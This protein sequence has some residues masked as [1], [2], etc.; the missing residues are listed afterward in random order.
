MQ[1]VLGVSESGVQSAP[2][3]DHP[4]GQSIAP[5]LGPCRYR[6]PATERAPTRAPVVDRRGGER[7]HGHVRLRCAVRRTGRKRPVQQRLYHLRAVRAQCQCDTT[8]NSHTRTGSRPVIQAA[9]ALHRQRGAHAILDSRYQPAACSTLARPTSA[10]KACARVVCLAA[11]PRKHAPSDLLVASA[12]RT[13]GCRMTSTG[14]GSSAEYSACSRPA[15][16]AAAAASVAARPGP[17]N[18]ASA[19]PRPP[20]AAAP[21]PRPGRP[22]PP[23]SAA[24]AAAASRSA[25][26]PAACSRPARPSRGENLLATR[27]VCRFAAC[28][29]SRR[30]PLHAHAA[31]SAAPSFCQQGASSRRRVK[32]RPPR[33]ARQQQRSRAA[34]TGRPPARPRGSCARAHAHSRGGR[35][36]GAHQRAI[37]HTTGPACTAACASSSCARR[38]KRALRGR[39]PS[40]VS[41]CC[42]CAYVCCPPQHDSCAPRARSGASRAQCSPPRAELQATETRSA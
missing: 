41:I 32:Q 3:V 20:S 27:R 16:S 1:Y 42:A 10:C 14:G 17:L 33:A 40:A 12:A 21:P 7:E 11:A 26:A 28:A 6:A 22:P 9:S 29:G 35:A 37:C 18:P 24:A 25:T 23:P 4:A 5:G 39:R 19:P 38:L 2:G 8:N 36:R 30:A 31:L 34:R 15:A 13:L